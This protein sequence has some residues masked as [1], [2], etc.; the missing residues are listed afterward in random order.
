M[1]NE[2]SE[3][4]QT[5]QDPLVRVHLTLPAAD[6]PAPVRSRQRSWVPDSRSSSRARRTAARRSCT[7]SFA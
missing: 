5:A 3:S 6:A 4:S 7:S 1:G 2:R